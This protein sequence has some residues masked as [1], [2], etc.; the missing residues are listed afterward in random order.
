MWI[1][2][3]MYNLYDLKLPGQESLEKPEQ[4][5]MLNWVGVTCNI[6]G[7]VTAIEPFRYN[8]FWIPKQAPFCPIASP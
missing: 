5:G 7:I 2:N 6:Y 3:L 4:A 8:V 1:L